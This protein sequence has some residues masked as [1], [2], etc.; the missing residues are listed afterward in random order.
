VKIA[1]GACTD[2]VVLFV[3][4]EKGWAEAGAGKSEAKAAAVTA[5]AAQEVRDGA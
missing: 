3:Q 2:R 5:A 4:G 1:C